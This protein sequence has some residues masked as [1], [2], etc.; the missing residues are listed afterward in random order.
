MLEFASNGIE[1][2]KNGVTNIK[3]WASS[4]L[5]ELW[6]GAKDVGNNV[7]YYLQEK[8]EIATNWVE[9]NVNQIGEK[10]ELFW[11]NGIRE[12]DLFFTN[13]SEG[14]L[15]HIKTP[16]DNLFNKA[17]NTFDSIGAFGGSIINQLSV[18][19][20]LYQE[21]VDFLKHFIV[22]VALDA[23]S[24]EIKIQGITI[25][26][27]IESAYDGLTQYITGNDDI[28]EK[29]VGEYIDSLEEVIKEI[30]TDD[31]ED[32]MIERACNLCA[33]VV[34]Q[35]ESYLLDICEYKYESEN[36]INSD[37]VR[38][39]QAKKALLQDAMINSNQFFERSTDEYN[40]KDTEITLTLENVSRWL[41]DNGMSDYNEDI[42]IDSLIAIIAML[43]L[44]LLQI[45]E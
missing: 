38:T 3:N 21:S 36:Q 27:T 44:N 30:N 41:D 19:V 25:D 31:Q 23:Y 40:E 5:P 28:S 13:I 11:N 18:Y 7:G 37:Y 43:D 35:F 39:V 15:L 17:A 2:T 24:N 33:K 42:D 32:R 26:E 20:M 16:V 4:T 8:A 14:F 22:A 1:S 45:V 29:Q 34:L 12:V 10:A 6:N 9:E